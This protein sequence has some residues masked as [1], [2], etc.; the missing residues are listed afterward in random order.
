ML[1]T[2]VLLSGL[3][4][5]TGVPGRIVAAWIDA[6]FEL[7]MSL[8]QVSEVARVLAYPK[9][10]D[11][12]CWDQER[13]ESFIK[14]LHVRAEVIDLGSTAAEVPRDPKDSPVLAPL[15]AAKADL[16]VTG[17]AD[18]LALRSGHPIET[19]TEFGSRL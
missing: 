6:E 17:D 18:L 11:R 9:I 8:D 13:I 1:D 3:M 19:P 5:P 10:R 16:L 4:T 15:V 14:Q 2:N 12:L 7:V